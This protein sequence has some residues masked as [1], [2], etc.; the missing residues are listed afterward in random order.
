[1]PKRLKLLHEWL[2]GALD[3]DGFDI[4]PAS[5]DASFRRY[6]RVTLPNGDSRIAMDAPPERED[7]RPF[8]DIAGRLGELGLN[9]PVIFAE[10]FD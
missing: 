6:F 1:M 9:V 10:V 3:L 8:V 7:C 5:G 4:E 2:S